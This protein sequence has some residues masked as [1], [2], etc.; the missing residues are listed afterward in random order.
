MY[1]K[2]TGP[3]KVATLSGRLIMDIT[4]VAPP[5]EFFGKKNP[6]GARRLMGPMSPIMAGKVPGPASPMKTGKMPGPPRIS[7]AGKA[8]WLANAATMA[9]PPPVMGLTGGSPPTRT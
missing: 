3:K 9:S 5:V 7:K 8:P 1:S 2:L 6:A 4:E